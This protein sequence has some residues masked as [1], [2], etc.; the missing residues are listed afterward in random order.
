ME[1]PILTEIDILLEMFDVPIDSFTFGEK[2]RV[3]HNYDH[4]VDI[5][6]QLDKRDLLS[7]KVLFL[8]A[9]YHDVIYNPKSKTNEEDSVEVF[10]NDAHYMCS[11]TEDERNEVVGIILDT[12]TH[13]PTSELS[14]IF[15]ELDLNILTRPLD[16]LIEYEEKIFKEFQFVDWK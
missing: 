6:E 14:G 2:H 11:L 3:Y 10:L 5:C 16:E 8:A 1:K 7:N 9:L 13:T 4:V 15:C 12:K